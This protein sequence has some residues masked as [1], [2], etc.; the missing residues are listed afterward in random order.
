MSSFAISF[1]L[2]DSASRPMKS[3][4]GASAMIIRQSAG[5]SSSER[6][7]SLT[8]KPASENIVWIARFSPEVSPCPFVKQTIGISEAVT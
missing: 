2:S 1:A 4:S 3:Y 5:M 7:T 8:S 6:S